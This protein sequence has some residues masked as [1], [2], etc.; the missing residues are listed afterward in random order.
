MATRHTIKSCCGRKTFI[1]ETSKPIRKFQLPLFKQEGFSAPE[2]FKVAGIFYVSDG[3]VIATA[4][5]GS[6]RIS[7]YC[8]GDECEQ[9]LDVFEELLDRVVSTK[10]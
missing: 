8:H 2:N 3:N 6:N 5:F 7:V 1:F 10:I 9:K 4:P